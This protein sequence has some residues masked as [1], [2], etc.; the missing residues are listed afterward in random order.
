[1]RKLKPKL[2]PICQSDLTK[3][4]ALDIYACPG[5]EGIFQISLINKNK[6]NQL[7]KNKKE[8]KAF[9]G[10]IHRQSRQKMTRKKNDLL[11]WFGAKDAKRY[12]EAIGARDWK[13]IRKL[14]KM[15][16]G[17]PANRILKLKGVL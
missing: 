10:R 16:P 15:D 9:T 17:N 8:Y 3:N 11:Y 7:F 1:M 5:C 4:N 6:L 14:A 13:T 2:C 12:L